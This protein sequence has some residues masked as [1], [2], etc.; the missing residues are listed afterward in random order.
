METFSI[1]YALLAVQSALLGIVTPALRAVVV[2]VN[3]EEQLLYLHFYY[4]G[5]VEEQVIE[6]WRCAIT[7]ASADLGP[8]CKLDNGVQ[9]LDYPKKIPFCG[10]YAYLRKE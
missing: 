6:L 5:E 2:D 7:E 9:R 4:D 1:E 8:D 3:K 10:R